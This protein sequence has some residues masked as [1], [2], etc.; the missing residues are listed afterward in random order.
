MTDAL[1]A[2]KFFIPTSRPNQVMRDRLHTRT[3]EGL[4]GKLTVVCAP[5]GFGKTTLVSGIA[6]KFDPPPAVWVSLE[7][8]D[9]DLMRF[10]HL[11]VEA[12]RL[13]VARFGAA[14]SSLLDA[15]Q[16]PPAEVLLPALLND[17]ASLTLALVLVLDDYH[18][19]E[20]RAS[21]EALAFL[22]EHQPPCLHLIVT[23]RNYPALPLA[24]LRARS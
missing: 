18:S 20:S 19:V 1:I 13:S 9:S 15:T 11:I 24:R 4:T 16:P 21:D 8:S 6:R 17:F 7:Q 12:I 22:L 14:T 23:T 3:K 2:T 5:A 10:I